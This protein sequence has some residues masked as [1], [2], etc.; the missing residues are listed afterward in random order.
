MATVALNGISHRYPSTAHDSVSDI[1]LQVDDGEF[2]VLLGGPGSGKSTLLRMIQGME[3]PT[4]GTVEIG[5][6]DATGLSP[7]ERDVTMAFENY[8]LYPHM[9]VAQNM[10]FALRLAGAAPDQIDTRVTA[11][12]QRLGLRNVLDSAPDELDGSQRQVVALGRALVRN[13]AVFVMDEPLTAMPPTTRSTVRRQ[14]RELQ[15]GL[16]ITTIYATADV[17]TAA[18]VADRVAV[19][20]A[21]RI[22][23]VC[24]PDDLQHCSA[25][26]D[27][28][29][30]TAGTAA[31]SREV[32]GRTAARPAPTPGAG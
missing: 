6:A 30:P 21:G 14:I 31:Q 20:D 22:V 13:P 18:A 32:R 11:A 15:R 4:A 27:I 28:P 29:A 8:A 25:A 12:A 5:G 2:L 7:S 9:T 24:R 1:N 19:L 17:D 10:G 3:R 16:G 23:R 26:A